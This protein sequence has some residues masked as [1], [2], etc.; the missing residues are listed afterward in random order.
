MLLLATDKLSGALLRTKEGVGDF[1]QDAGEVALDH[2]AEAFLAQLLRARHLP[3][4]L[5]AAAAAPGSCA[6][7]AAL[8]LFVPSPSA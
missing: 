7:A 1:Q 4:I 3:L 6:A 5:V 2:G 8:L